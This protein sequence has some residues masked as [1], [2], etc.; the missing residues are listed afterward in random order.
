VRLYLQS[1]QSK[2]DC[3]HGSSGRSPAL[4]VWSSEFKFQYYKK[5]PL[6]YTDRTW[7]V[8]HTQKCL[9]GQTNPA[10]SNGLQFFTNTELT[11]NRT[12][13]NRERPQI[14][15]VKFTKSIGYNLTLIGP[16][17]ES[18]AVSKRAGK[19]VARMNVVNLTVGLCSLVMTLRLKELAQ[20]VLNKVAISQTAQSPAGRHSLIL[21][22]WPCHLQQLSWGFSRPN[23]S[24]PRFLSYIRITC[25]WCIN[26]ST[27]RAK[28]NQDLK[29]R[30]LNKDQA[31][32]LSVGLRSEKSLCPHT[33]LNRD[34]HFSIF[35]L[36]HSCQGNDA[37]KSHKQSVFLEV[38]F[39]LWPPFAPVYVF[40]HEFQLA[41]I[42]S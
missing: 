42:T 30:G 33:L 14:I 11:L 5:G 2:K 18:A 31:D 13:H 6:G 37:V 29:G 15:K 28:S 40:P 3:R 22:S 21:S 27:S 16:L 25:R 9:F 24:H 41:L 38:L 8:Q 32:F 23:L 35:H 20:T 10:D 17:R 4:Q 7:L 1:N 36:H 19:N 39:K 12:G 34:C 26:F